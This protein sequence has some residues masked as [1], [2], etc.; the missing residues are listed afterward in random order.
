[1]IEAER[2]SLLSEPCTRDLWDRAAQTLDAD[3]DLSNREAWLYRVGGQIQLS[4]CEPIEVSV[5]DE[6]ARLSRKLEEGSL[7]RI[8]GRHDVAV[9]WMG[10]VRWTAEGQ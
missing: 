9:P 8:C 4:M 10:V 2:S 6:F 3:F 1:M 5:E 7:L